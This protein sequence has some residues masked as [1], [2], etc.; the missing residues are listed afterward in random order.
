[1]WLNKKRLSKI[2]A[3][4]IVFLCVSMSAIDIHAV[5]RDITCNY[6]GGISASIRT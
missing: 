2:T 6:P 5:L 4:V 3:F 1:M